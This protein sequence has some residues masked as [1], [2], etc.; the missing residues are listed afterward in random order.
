MLHTSRD[1]VYLSPPLLYYKTRTTLLRQ[2]TSAPSSRSTA[3]LSASSATVR[4]NT[5]LTRSVARADVARV[6]KAALPSPE[7]RALRYL[8]AEMRRDAYEVRH[9]GAHLRREEMRSKAKEELRR[10][11]QELLKQ[12]YLHFRH[13][14]L[15]YDAKSWTLECYLETCN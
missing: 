3:L 9:G 14:W 13:M 11:R 15:L 2:P 8:R 1:G 5:R 4:L 10:R 12:R 6:C 7:L